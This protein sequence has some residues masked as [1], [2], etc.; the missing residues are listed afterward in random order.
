[1]SDVQSRKRRYDATGRREQM[2]RNRERVLEHARRLFVAQGFTATTM[3]QIAAAAGVST[4]TVFSGFGS[5]A[6]LLKEAIETA[7]AGDAAAIP[8]ADRTGLRRVHQ[9]A[10]A[11]EVI[12]LFM[13]VIAEIAERAAPIHAVAMAAA[14]NDAEIAAM[15]SNLENQRLITAARVA[16]TAAARADVTDQD[17]IDNLRDAIWVLNSPLQYRA[18][19]RERGWSTNRYRDFVTDLLVAILAGSRARP[20]G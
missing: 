8:L 2:R 3:P 20:R 11:E 10:T 13:A 5:K 17:W 9:A 1:M 14:E 18:I 6:N 4:P 12:H 7:V 19:T 15:I 16:A